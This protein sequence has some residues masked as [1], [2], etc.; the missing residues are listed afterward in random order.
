MSMLALNE[1]VFDEPVVLPVRP[2][3]SVTSQ[4]VWFALAEKSW[5]TLAVVPT[6][7]SVRT[8]RVVLSLAAAGEQHGARS[9][10]LLDATGAQM[11][12]Y[13]RIATSFRLSGAAN[14]MI[15]RLDPV[16]DNPTALG[17]ARAASA[18]LVVA[19]F[20]ES[21]LS[22]MHRLVEAIGRERVAGCVV[23]S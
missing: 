9:I 1:P 3:D 13:Q 8:V 11:R 7:R 18:V 23:V 22:S 2:V 15:V 5:R 4:R 12:D 16:A 20:G 10:R 21:R 17:L 6:E 19:R 14:C